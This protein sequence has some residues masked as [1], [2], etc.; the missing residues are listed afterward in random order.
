MWMK[1]YTTVIALG[2]FL[3]P[4]AS[5][6]EVYSHSNFLLINSTH[7]THSVHAHYLT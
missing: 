5:D 7:N 6:R 4:I 2:R 1:M 3:L